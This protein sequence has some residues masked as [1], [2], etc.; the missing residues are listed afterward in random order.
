M[1]QLASEKEMILA[2][3]KSLAEYNLSQEPVLIER[4]QTLLNVHNSA[5]QLITEVTEKKSK[6]G[7]NCLWFN[8]LPFFFQL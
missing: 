3:N 2:S 1:K 4:R 8:K 5:N 6:L 7:E